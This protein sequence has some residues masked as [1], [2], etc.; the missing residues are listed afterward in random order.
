[1]I[2]V[3]A[4]KNILNRLGKVDA[5]N[6]F[7]LVFIALFQTAGSLAISQV[8]YT[9][10]LLEFLVIREFSFLAMFAILGVGKLILS[11]FAIVRSL[12]WVTISAFFLGI[13]A[14]TSVFDSLLVA[15]HLTPEPQLVSRLLVSLLPA[16]VALCIAGLI[17]SYS[18]EFHRKNT[19]LRD[20]LTQLIDTRTQA[21]E[22]IRTRQE[23]LIARVKSLLN[24]ELAGI[25]PTKL[26]SSSN[27]MRHL[28]DD[29][30][31]PLSY[32]LERDVELD[33][34]VTITIPSR[35]LPWSQI[36]SHTMAGNPLRP[37]ATA[38]WLSFFTAVFFIKNYGSNGLLIIIAILVSFI[39]VLWMARFWW[40]RLT[41][42]LSTSGRAMFF[43]LILGLAAIVSAG[44]I[45]AVSE[46]NI[47]TLDK[48]VPWVLE[49]ELVP[50]TLALLSGTHA[51]QSK[52]NI[53]LGI[54]V[55]E[56]QRE[57]ISLNS[58][59]R[60]LQRNMSRVLHG[61]I[62]HS[63]ATAIY[64]L[65]Q[66]DG[67][68]AQVIITEAKEKIVTSLDQ[69]SQPEE[70]K[71]NLSESFA[72]LAELWRGVIDLRFDVTNSDLE[73]IEADKASAN[74]I[75]ELVTEACTN[76]IRHG[77]AQQISISINVDESHNTI[78]LIV[79][80][81]GHPLNANSR[82]GLGSQLLQEMC[83]SWSRVQ[84]GNL[85]RLEA[86]IPLRK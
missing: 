20:A 37:F 59:Y 12:P 18:R 77:E 65:Q 82:N 76:A 1:M 58:E 27:D 80:N 30:I 5:I 63:I 36:V 56:L 42:T 49:S 57:V 48:I 50:W 28:L 34:A 26:S 78:T 22:K 53:E 33:A 16:F 15:T 19:A 35:R 29:V 66:S 39:S 60:Q 40:P 2:E 9:G 25:A 7:S 51:L 23:K 62:Q 31:R 73:L 46:F 86:L 71:L 10:R 43:S 75:H 38:L 32:Q 44:L 47:F 8:N 41:S 67:A 84:E 14:S 79:M 45:T 3:E 85:V 21:T 11:R 6:W 4:M 72:E 55:E 13:T 64:R 54:A 17:V 74:G 52:T 61:P 69:L 70:S 81:D 68:S 83:L 24:E